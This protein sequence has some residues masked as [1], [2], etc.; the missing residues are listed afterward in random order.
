[1]GKHPDQTSIWSA[2]ENEDDERSLTTVDGE[3]SK[4]QNSQAEK[5]TFDT[6]SVV[7]IE[8]VDE[9]DDL[10]APLDIKWLRKS[11]DLE[12][13]TENQQNRR[14]NESDLLN[15]S[16]KSSNNSNYYKESSVVKTDSED[17][18]DSDE[19]IDPTHLQDT[20]IEDSIVV[21]QDENTELSEKTQ[22]EQSNP[23]VSGEKEDST[24]VPRASG[25]PSI[26]ERALASAQE[27]IEALS[28]ERAIDRP[29]RTMTKPLDATQTR[30]LAAIF[31]IK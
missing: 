2:S 7:S 1:M 10:T 23:Q 29:P 12:E 15:S 8:E 31:G 11:K 25:M 24:D 9:I 13:S 30:R 16:T 4:S 14:E 22:E 6:Q 26:A 21:K 5:T 27:E 20:D 19:E 28:Y 18:I 3:L 17:F